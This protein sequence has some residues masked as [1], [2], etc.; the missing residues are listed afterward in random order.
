MTASGV[1]RDGVE[2]V[3]TVLLAFA[4]VATAWSG[5]QAS[6]WNG[7]QAKAGARANA[8]RIEASRESALANSQTQIDVATFSSWVDAYVRK[9]S[10]LAQFYFDRFRKEFKPAVD[11][12]VATR[13]LKN[14]DAPL[15]PFAMPQYQLAARAQAERLDAQAE[16]LAGEA[17]LDIQRSSNYVLAVVLF[18][19][20]LFF[21]GMSTKLAT[22]RLR[23]AMLTIGCLVS[24]AQPSGLRPPPSRFRSEEPYVGLHCRLRVARRLAARNPPV[25]LVALRGRLLREHAWR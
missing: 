8:T 18:A 12:W 17:R 6:R 10:T 15:T 14:A 16:T 23:W 7:E 4:T 20:A 19:S 3:A 2:L 13:P 11:A 24:S 9:E 1:R 21:A 5:Y 22:P 25:G